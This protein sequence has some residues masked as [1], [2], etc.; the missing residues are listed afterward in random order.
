MKQWVWHFFLRLAFLPSNNI[1]VWL[2]VFV[3]SLCDVKMS[4]DYRRWPQI[5]RCWICTT[6][7]SCKAH[8]FFFF[9]EK[10]WALGFRYGAQLDSA[11]FFFFRLKPEKQLMGLQSWTCSDV[12]V[13]Q[14]QKQNHR[15]SVIESLS[16]HKKPNL[17]AK[18]TKRLWT[19]GL[20][21]EQCSDKK[22]TK[23]P[24]LRQYS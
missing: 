7:S 12:P 10:S 1:S 22:N 6:S 19:P 13:R 18:D 15:A 2:K 17:L 20:H 4:E 8:V 11:R 23:R 16:E 24:S 5:R 14:Q 21:T 3:S 9:P